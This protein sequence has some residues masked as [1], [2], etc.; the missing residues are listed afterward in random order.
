MFSAGPRVLLGGT[1]L[2]GGAAGMHGAA[3]RL[4]TLE[5]TVVGAE[6]GAADAR[7]G[8]VLVP[9]G[10]ERNYVIQS[11]ENGV[12]EFERGRAD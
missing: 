5:A 7:A 4:V 9:S 6:S 3:S 1:G 8:V 10:T 2:V 12:Q 11:G